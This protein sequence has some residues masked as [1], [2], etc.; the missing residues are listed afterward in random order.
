MIDA[1][2]PVLVHFAGHTAIG[3][4]YNDNTNKIAMYDTWS[5]VKNKIKWG[6]PIIDSHGNSYAMQSVTVVILDG[7]ILKSASNA[8][9]R[10]GVIVGIYDD[11]Y[12]QNPPAYTPFPPMSSDIMQPN[13]YNFAPG[14]NIRFYAQFNSGYCDTYAWT[15]NWKVELY[16][17]T[18]TY[19]YMT[20]TTQGYDN[21]P[22]YCKSSSQWKTTASSNI[23]DYEWERNEDGSINGKI[24]VQ[25]VDINEH[26]T[27]SVTG[28]NQYG[29]SEYSNTVSFAKYASLPYTTGFESYL[30]DYWTSEP[31]NSNGCRYIGYGSYSP[32]SGNYCLAMAACN[33]GTYASNYADM[34]L[35]LQNEKNV[36][37]EFWWKDFGDEYHSDVDGIWFSNDGGSNFV[38][39]YDL[40][41][42]SYSNDVWRKFTVNISSIA[43]QQGLKLTKNFIVRFA[44]KD[45]YSIPTDG[46]AFDDISVY[47]NYTPPTPVT[48][49]T[50]TA[51][52]DAM[53]LMKSKPGYEYVKDKNYGS[54][55]MIKADEWTNSG[56]R[57]N[58]ISVFDF[59]LSMYP[60]S[61]LVKSAHLSL[62]ANNPQPSDGYKQM[63]N[64]STNNTGY[65]SNACWLKRIIQEWDENTVTY[66]TEPQTTTLHAEYLPISETYTQNYLNF[67]VT[68][69][70]VDMIKY[71]NASHGFM[72]ELADETKYTR[73]AFASSDHANSSLHPKLSIEYYFDETVYSVPFTVYGNTSSESNNWDVQGGDGKDKSYLVYIPT[74]MTIDASTCASAT[75]YDTKLEI[76]KADK[77]RTGAYNDDDYEDCNYNYY[78]S[79]LYG[80]SL[81]SGYYYFVVDG[82]NG[83]VGSF[84]LSVSNSSVLK[85][86]KTNESS[87][88][89]KKE[90]ENLME[91]KIYP[92]PVKDELYISTG[93]I[94]ANIKIFD[95][96]G[97]TLKTLQI[98][99]EKHIIDCSDLNQGV[100]VIQIISDQL[101]ESRIFEK[102]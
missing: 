100:Y 79:A 63:T 83:A 59:D 29:E 82:Y 70:V 80:V 71:P 16:H 6:D 78:A 51:T 68:R 67:D 97:R 17:K 64:L 48:V 38:K 35:N 72:L 28:V 26:T 94:E 52:K 92:N 27:I 66:S 14:D 57:T 99:S 43:E 25:T 15:F 69:L 75:G 18:G 93:S 54:Y 58:S 21:W 87:L 96:N 20:A 39:A 13:T 85:S 36:V 60:A 90:P 102:Q 88:T 37:L 86:A 10:K 56:Y 73:M 7:T 89:E 101:I 42:Q 4:G 9:C 76:F 62:Y 33:S 50:L 74:T 84:E 32:H 11:V 55:S 34:R 81:E 2:R 77:S 65:K 47:S 24:I 98:Q 19:E 31:S 45:N 41:G 49:N 22:T 91:I 44:Q 53:L 30:D 23:P 46:F 1:G 5:T 12:I 3:I 40:N 8:V 95:M 61:T